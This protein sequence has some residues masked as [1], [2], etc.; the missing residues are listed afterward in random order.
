MPRGRRHFRR[1][2]ELTKNENLCAK[3]MRE[4]LICRYG[5]MLIGQ[6]RDAMEGWM[7]VICASFEENEKCL[8]KDRKR[9]EAHK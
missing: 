8:S 3:W 1:V 7:A 9:P 4:C 6:E 5:I 2:S